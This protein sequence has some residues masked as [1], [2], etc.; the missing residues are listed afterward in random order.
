MNSQGWTK[1]TISW[2]HPTTGKTVSRSRLCAPNVQKEPGREYSPI[3]PR[4]PVYPLSLSDNG[5]GALHITDSTDAL[6][7]MIPY[8]DGSHLNKGDIPMEVALGMALAMVEM[9]KI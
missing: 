4:L 9:S 1:S 2:P 6:I 8:D 5:H 3:I 7:A